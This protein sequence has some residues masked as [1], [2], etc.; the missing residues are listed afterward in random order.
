MQKELHPRYAVDLEEDKAK[1][2]RE[3]VAKGAEIISLQCQLS[4]AKEEALKNIYL[5]GY[6]SKFTE[7][8]IN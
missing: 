7:Q 5:D 8:E 1:M 6:L 2:L 3:I 4:L